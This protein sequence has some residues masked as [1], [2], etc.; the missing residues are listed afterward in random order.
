MKVI[1]YIEVISISSAGFVPIQIVEP[2]ECWFELGYTNVGAFEIYAPA[3][4]RNLE[5]LRKGNFVKIPNFRYAWVITSIQYT[6]TAGGTRMISAKGYEAIWVLKKS[7]IEKN[8]YLYNTV[9][10]AFTMLI[11]KWFKPYYLNGYGYETNENTTS[12]NLTNVAIATRSNLLEFVHNFA[13]IYN[14]NIYSTYADNLIRFG[15]RQGEDK[16]SSIR[17]SQSNDNLLSFNYLSDDDKK[18]NT[19]YVVAKVNDIEYSTSYSTLPNNA[20]KIT[21]IKESSLSNK[22]EDE[23]GNEIELNL[24]NESDKAAYLDLLKEEGKLELVNHTTLTEISST[25]DLKNSKYVFDTDYKVGDIVEVKDE[26]FNI[27]TKQR[28]IKYTIRLESNGIVSEA[29]EFGE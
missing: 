3:T 21:V 7:V 9:D 25:I 6:F 24:T 20:G 13:K 18:A 17:F 5:C 19:V 22:Y 4:R 10:H 28:I 27:S 29:L 14:C 1:P 23:N 15:I 26:F 2:K 12:L 8:T 11:Y 16:S